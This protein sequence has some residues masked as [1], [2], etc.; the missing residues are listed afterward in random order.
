MT[1]VCLCWYNKP[2]YLASVM[3]TNV[4]MSRT[5]APS[6]ERS[7]IRKFSLLLW[8]WWRVKHHRSPSFLTERKWVFYSITTVPIVPFTCFIS[9]DVCMRWEAIRFGIHCWLLLVSSR[10][11]I[12]IHPLLLCIPPKSLFGIQ[13]W[14]PLSFTAGGGNRFRP[15]CSLLPLREAGRQE[16]QHGSPCGEGH[17]PQ[18]CVTLQISS[19]PHSQ[20]ESPFSPPPSAAPNWLRQIW[21]SSSRSPIPEE[22]KQILL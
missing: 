11:I 3:R 20:L 5:S 18:R 17:V 21:F 9:W 15:C 10:C 19:P 16:F 13:Q 1:I 2:V 12:S 14:I 7:P 8:C 22:R 6:V 4:S